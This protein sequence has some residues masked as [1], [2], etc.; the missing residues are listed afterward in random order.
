[1]NRALRGHFGSLETD[2][3]DINATRALACE[4]LAL[5]LVNLLSEPEKLD[6]LYEL[7]EFEEQS[8]GHRPRQNES[9]M[10]SLESILGPL[11]SETSPLLMTQS[12][13][14]SGHGKSEYAEYFEGLNA[15]EIA[16]VSGAKVFL[17][18]KPIQ[19]IVDAIWKGDVVFWDKLS[20]DAVKHAQAYQRRTSDPFARI[21]V[22]MYLKAFEFLFFAAFLGLYY[23]V[24]LQ[25]QFHRVTVLEILLDIWFISFTYN[26]TT[27][28]TTTAG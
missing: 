20:T 2:E 26:G 8:S 5:K 14:E 22:P 25:R 4:A 15:L 18:Q 19:R 16:A 27:K 17:S 6:L 7:P 23:A 9:E 13:N 12:T 11:A 28:A 10:P 21:R 3:D 24:I 1:M